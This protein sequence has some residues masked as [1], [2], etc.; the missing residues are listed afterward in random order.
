MGKP[1]Q[2]VAYYRVSTKKQGESGLG[3]DAQRAAVESY[4]ARNGLDIIQEFTEIETG[5]RKRT[6]PQIAA[7]IRAAKQAGAV[8]LIAKLDR[9]AR[10][11]HFV[12]GLMESGVSFTAVDMPQIDNLTI[13]I[14]AAVAEQEAQLI[15][16]R[17][18]A[19]LAA[20]KAK[21]TKLGNPQHLT[22]EAQQAGA[23]SMRAAAVTAYQPVMGYIN[24]LSES[25]LGHAAIATKLNREGHKTRRGGKF[26]PMTVWRILDRAGGE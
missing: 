14:L 12:S 1:M 7:A 4:A 5:T 3:L 21:G 20:A 2:A 8:L 26:Y 16:Q 19:A 13:H 18:K 6:R 24:L 10:N 15:S 25:G 17:T 9:L 11:V 22:Q 23:N